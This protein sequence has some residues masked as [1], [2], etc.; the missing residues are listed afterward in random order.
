M[1][2]VIAK[3]DNT[4]R[5]RLSWIQSFAA[6]FGIVPKPIYG[7]IVLAAISGSNAST[8]SACKDALKAEKPFTVDFEKVEV[9]PDKGEVVALA[10]AGGAL[11]TLREK[12]SAVAPVSEQWVPCTTLLHDNM[13]NLNW[14]RM[15]MSEMFQPFTATVDRIE[16][17]KRSNLVDCLELKGEDT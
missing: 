17:V 4:A 15:A 11:L 3:L 8:I 12:L 13:A 2:Y 5:A 14:I 9:L 16:F 7:H 6:S 1:L 10:A